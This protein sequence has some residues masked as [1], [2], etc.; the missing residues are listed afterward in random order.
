MT[1]I[2]LFFASALIPVS[3][4]LPSLISLRL[5]SIATLV[6]V[7]GIA[8]GMW[9]FHNTQMGF[10]DRGDWRVSMA[11]GAAIATVISFA[12]LITACFGL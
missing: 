2:F 12:S 1:Y 4:S 7:V 8:V 6:F 11:R 10:C 9:Q 3:L 5:I